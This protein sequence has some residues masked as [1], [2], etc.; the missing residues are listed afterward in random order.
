[1]KNM[2]IATAVA[3][4]L[5]YLP[6]GAH[7]A[8]SPDDLAQIR[9]QLQSLIHRVDKLEQ[10]NTQLKGENEDLKAQG[11]YLKAEAKGLRKDAA[12]VSADAAKVKGAD[13]AGRVTVKGDMRYR[14]EEISDDSLTGAVQT[15]DRDRDRVR[16]RVAIEAKATDNILVGIGMTT[17]EGGDPRSGNQSLSGTFNKKGFDLDLAYFDWK[18]ASW[19]DL[20]G[21]K[22]KQP[23]F[24]PGGSTYF[25]DNDITPEGLA[26]TFDRGIW[27]GS[28]YGYWI[29][30][31]SGLEN[32][33][34]ADTMLF[35]GQV[36]ARIPVGAATLTVAGNYY[37]LAAGQGRSPF[38]N[39]S[40]NGNTTV[41]V[42]TTPILVN[43]YRIVGL[44]GQFDTTLGSWPLQVWAD[45]A[46][47]Q[48]ADDLDTAWAAGVLFGKASNPKSWEFGFAY[49]TLEKD[50]LFGQLVD[51]DF[52][53]GVTDTK[54]WVL[55]GAYAPVRNWTLNATYFINERNVDVANSAG[56][57][58][59]DYNRL[60]LDFNV[61]F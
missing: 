35:G 30:E 5:S 22:M 50:A 38:F 15:A 58:G 49:E 26:V 37:D 13:W 61:K 52:G 45:F 18:F 56:Q 24:K 54:G 47:N 60:Q 44:S 3:A 39:A 16:A 21:G 23:F 7:A 48:E 32:T 9:D 31:I 57:T 41:L 28:A 46:Q 6:A 43:D 2:L 34:T 27:F 4:T 14:H 59:V 53:S 8:S 42:G 17:T 1:V 29:T 33:R 20:I 36:G 51:S 19:G 10:E 55:R 40:S 12:T 11:D 25:W